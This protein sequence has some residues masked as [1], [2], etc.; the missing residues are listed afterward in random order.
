MTDLTKRDA[1]TAREVNA[2][3]DELTKEI[4]EAA[5]RKALNPYTGELLT[6]EQIRRRNSQEKIVGDAE[7]AL[8]DERLPAGMP[9]DCPIPPSMI[10]NSFKDWADGWGIWLMD[11]AFFDEQVDE[12]KSASPCSYQPRKIGWYVHDNDGG[13]GIDGSGPGTYAPTLDGAWNGYVARRTSKLAIAGKTA[14]ALEMQKLHARAQPSKALRQ[15]TERKARL[16]LELAEY[17]RPRGSDL[18]RRLQ[19]EAYMD[20]MSAP[21]IQANLDALRVGPRACALCNGMASLSVERTPGPKLYPCPCCDPTPEWNVDEIAGPWADVPVGL[22]WSEEVNDR[23][24]ETTPVGTWWLY[25]GV[26]SVVRDC[27]EPQ[28]YKADS[29]G[30]TVMRWVTLTRPTYL[31]LDSKATERDLQGEV[32]TKVYC[33]DRHEWVPWLEARRSTSL[34]VWS[35]ARVWPIAWRAAAVAL[36]TSLGWLVDTAVW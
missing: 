7:K 33:D 13:T 21:E 19:A 6:F 8:G 27:T 1:P 36:V 28:V 30:H 15:A 4:Y 23:H 11:G 26:L 24:M 16:A 5:E 12:S 32:S 10:R 22:T 18:D 20:E 3:Q 2:P 34:V 35:A 14:E 17:K 9:I 31:E 25:H 29:D